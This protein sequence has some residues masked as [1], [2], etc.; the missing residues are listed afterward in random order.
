MNKLLFIFLSLLSSSANSA[1]D[2]CAEEKK[3]FEPL[4][5]FLVEARPIAEKQKTVT[6]YYLNKPNY[7]SNI[8]E[9]INIKSEIESSKSTI[10]FAESSIKIYQRAISQW[11]EDKE[12]VVENRA[13][14]SKQLKKKKD[15]EV[16]LK[17]QEE[18][19]K[20][21]NINNL[22]QDFL[23]NYR[24]NSITLDVR[25]NVYSA[26]KSLA[27]MASEK[28]SCLSNNSCSNLDDVLNQFKTASDHFH[29]VMK[30]N[31]IKDCLNESKEYSF[32][33]S[34][35][36]EDKT[37]EDKDL[38]KLRLYYLKYYNKKI[39]PSTFYNWDLLWNN[40]TWMQN[41]VAGSIQNSNKSLNQVNQT[42]G[43]AESEVMLYSEDYSSKM[44][45]PILSIRA[46][47]QQKI[48]SFH[49][50]QNQKKYNLKY[51]NYLYDLEIKKIN[52]VTTPNQWLKNAL[53][54]TES[55]NHLTDY[56][57]NIEIDIK[58]STMDRNFFANKNAC[59]DI[60]N[61]IK[62]VK[63][64]LKALQDLEGQINRFKMSCNNSVGG[65][66][67][68]KKELNDDS[69]R[70]SIN[71]K[72]TFSEKIEKPFEQTNKN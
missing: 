9:L 37:K 13:R 12:L 35:F 29:E 62:Q 32:M 52:E 3:I 55:Q 64:D 71:L 22:S 26:E 53:T 39:S 51:F 46:D 57:R 59:E 34:Q 44:K 21:K 38:K 15:A 42:L 16:K 27:E 36:N 45:A 28:P 72:K 2:I 68:F 11:G 50:Q 30:S 54:A 61:N 4:D 20:I 63:V 43:K 49:K 60:E 56:L 65:F 23:E 7:L 40:T 18:R 66:R 17:E 8:D 14:I 47:A 25:L 69:R 70:S 48:D 19:F 33:M 6:G 67:Q 5:K 24:R 10:F 58:F 1:S 31:E 41:Q